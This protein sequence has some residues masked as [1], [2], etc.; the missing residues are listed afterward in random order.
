MIMALQTVTHTSASIPCKV[1]PIQGGL[2]TP[3]A[4]REGSPHLWAGLLVKP[5][6]M[7][8][9]GPLQL[10]ALNHLLLSNHRHSLQVV[11][12]GCPARG[13][14]LSCLPIPPNAG[15]GT[16]KVQAQL[17]PLAIGVDGPSLTGQGGLKY[18]Q[19]CIGQAEAPGLKVLVPVGHHCGHAQLLLLWGTCTIQNQVRRQTQA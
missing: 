4:P 18:L 19:P 6:A 5:A 3:K 1:P 7:P 15:T 12:C 10:S 11:A 9:A 14:Q 16:E 13:Q 8:R 17:S 2:M